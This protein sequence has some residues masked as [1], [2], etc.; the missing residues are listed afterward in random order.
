[1]EISE[2]DAATRMTIDGN[3]FD[4]RRYHEKSRA[5]SA[6][7]AGYFF[8]FFFFFFVFAKKHLFSY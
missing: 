6:H 1:M 8:F 4:A 2:T 5:R 3:I 7:E